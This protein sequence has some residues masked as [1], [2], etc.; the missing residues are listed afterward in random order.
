MGACNGIFDLK[1]ILED[2]RKSVRNFLDCKS[3]DEKI[4]IYDAEEIHDVSITG[5]NHIGSVMD[6]D[7]INLAPE[8]ITQG[9]FF[10]SGPGSYDMWAI[11]FGYTPNLS[12]EER[13]NILS[14]SSQP[15]YIFGTDGDAMSSPGLNID[16][17]NVLYD[18]SRDPIA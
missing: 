14:K 15:E 16:T 9:N 5:D 18:M 13:E 6:Y 11:E 7:P 4:E 12:D 17:W 2:T 8:G 10:P 1:N 3:N